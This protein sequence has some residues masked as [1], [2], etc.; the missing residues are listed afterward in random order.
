MD[1]PIIL[2]TGAGVGLEVGT[3]INKLAWIFHQLKKSEQSRIKFCIDT[4][5]IWAAGSD[6]SNKTLVRKFFSEFDEL[7][8]I[9]NIIC[10]HFNNSVGGLGS[11]TDRHADLLYGSINP[12]G[13]EAIAKFAY[14]H[15]IPLIMETPLRAVNPLT[16][17]DITF[18][19]E[20][21][22]VKKW[23]GI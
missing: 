17:A 9:D 12:A 15:K 8:G 20:L 18:G 16:D 4:C 10:I 13:L 23:I 6:I 22:T 3:Q 7:I 14:L 5:H 1:V 2:E 11:K 19:E 21:L